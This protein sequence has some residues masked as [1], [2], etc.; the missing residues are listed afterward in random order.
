MDKKPLSD[1]SIG[2]E[3]KKIAILLAFFAI[4]GIVLGIMLAGQLG[5]D[6]YA[7]IYRA[8]YA[9]FSLSFSEYFGWNMIASLAVRCAILDLLLAL[10]LFAVTF[11][12]I[13]LI[14]SESVLG[15]LGARFGF[16]ACLLVHLLLYDSILSISRSDILVH[17]VC[18]GILLL[19]FWKYG[20]DLLKGRLHRTKSAFSYFLKQCLTILLIKLAYCVLIFYL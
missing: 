6:T 1:S 3:L 18:G 14:A 20:L 5:D 4:A 13:H 8:I 10:L 7:T 15:F 11:G 19:G 2:I 17:L 16:S 9:H 12:K